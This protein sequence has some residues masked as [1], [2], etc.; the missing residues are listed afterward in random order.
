[1]LNFDQ[2]VSA[3]LLIRSLEYVVADLY[4]CRAVEFHNPTAKGV[5][6]R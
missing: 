1:M 4:L 6:I 2:I 5:R 3:L